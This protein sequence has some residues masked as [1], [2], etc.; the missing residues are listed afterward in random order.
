MGQLQQQVQISIHAPLAGSD[1]T[2]TRNVSAVIQFQS[3]LPS[4]GATVEAYYGEE[5]YAI[6][7]HAPLAGSD[8]EALRGLF[9][10]WRFQST[11]PSRGATELA[12]IMAKQAEFQS[13]LPSRGATCGGIATG[14]HDHYFNPRSPRGERL[15]PVPLP[16]PCLRFQS[17]LPSRGATTRVWDDV[18]LPEFQS[19]LP[20]RG[21]TSILHNICL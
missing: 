2:G 18:T 11:L 12:F 1:D 19:T 3:T 14:R 15:L 13:T 10:I 7:I 8:I 5:G 21:A 20:S 4:R 16:M 17:T 9:L 6:S